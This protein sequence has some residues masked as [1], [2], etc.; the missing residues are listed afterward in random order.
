MQAVVKKAGVP[1][2]IV[3]DIQVGCVLP[4]GGGAAISRMAM[5]AAG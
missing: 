1:A 4:P 3:Q 2:G 5:L